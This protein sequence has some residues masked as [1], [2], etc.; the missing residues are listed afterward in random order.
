[1]DQPDDKEGY[2]GGHK[3]PMNAMRCRC[4]FNRRIQWVEDPWQRIPCFG[5]RKSGVI[6][7]QLRCYDGV[8]KLLEKS[9]IFTSTNTRSDS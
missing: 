7:E 3:S 1:M 4:K 2:E 9:R 5:K 8:S 6:V